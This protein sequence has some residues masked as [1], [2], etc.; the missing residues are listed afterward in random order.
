MNA[1]LTLCA[2]TAA[3]F[4]A[5]CGGGGGDDAVPLGGGVP[6]VDSGSGSVPPA[7]QT[8]DMNAAVGSVLA[9]GASFPNM[10]A[11]LQGVDFGASVTYH[12]AVEG[13]FRG[14]VYKRSIRTVTMTASTASP[15]TSED[16]VFFT[17]NPTRFTGYIGQDGMP[18]VLELMG[19]LPAAG[20]I[21][22]SGPY[23]HA[24][25]Y[26][27]DGQTVLGENWVTWS[28]EPDAGSTALACLSWAGDDRR[29][30]IKDC[31]RTDATGRVSGATMTM[32]YDFGTLEF[33]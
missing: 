4:L 13:I 6:L 23:L 28:L 31:L 30:Y 18:A 10:R 20:M 24:I 16:S 7:A 29:V 2:A 21:G 3:V 19:D 8:F 11:S 12:P 26:A 15:L 1:R 22:E 25:G 32:Y 5:A 27:A 9:Q 33:R 14:G 17:L